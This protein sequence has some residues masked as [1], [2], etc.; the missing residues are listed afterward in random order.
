MTR[1]KG[2]R[3]LK[4]LPKAAISVY[5]CGLFPRIAHDI[6]TAKTQSNES[7][8]LALAPKAFTKGIKFKFAAGTRFEAKGFLLLCR[9]ADRFKEFRI[10]ATG[11]GGARRFFPTE[12]EPRPAL[13]S[14]VHGSIEPALIPFGWIINTTESEFKAAQERIKGSS[15]C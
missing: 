12:T 1:R 2:N 3:G 6:V 10:Q 15:R 13:S 9:N 11:A 14:H 8:G 5:L 7:R 4:P